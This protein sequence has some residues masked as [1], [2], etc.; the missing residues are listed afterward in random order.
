MASSKN[1]GVRT[2]GKY[3]LIEI[4]GRKAI[5]V[6]VPAANKTRGPDLSIV[7]D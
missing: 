3:L 7:I 1:E 2:L 5:A 4:P 6:D